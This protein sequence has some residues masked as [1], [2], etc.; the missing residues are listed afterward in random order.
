ME[1][2][3]PAPK[4][5]LTGTL[6]IRLAERRVIRRTNM[7][8]TGEKPFLLLNIEVIF[9]FGKVVATK[10]CVCHCEPLND[11]IRGKAISPTFDI[12]SANYLKCHSYLEEYIIF[13]VN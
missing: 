3:I 8:N 4:A 7:T 9:K 10:P 1:I 6:I 13:K 2:A 11:S 5:M 12:L